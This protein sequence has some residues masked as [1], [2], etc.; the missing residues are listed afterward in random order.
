M[1]TYSLDE[2]QDKLLGKKGTAGRD[3]F[4]YELQMDLMGKAIII[5]SNT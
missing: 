2:V 1:K 4:E 3:L 5:L